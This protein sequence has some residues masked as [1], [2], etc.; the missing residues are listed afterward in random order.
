[1]Y[2]TILQRLG[3]DDLQTTVSAIR[4]SPIPVFNDV[5]Q[6]GASD[7]IASTQYCWFKCSTCKFDWRSWLQPSIIFVS[8]SFITERCP[9]CR[10]NHVPAYKIETGGCWRT[11]QQSTASRNNCTGLI[12][13]EPAGDNA[14]IS[15]WSAGVLMT[16]AGLKWLIRVFQ[17]QQA[18][19]LVL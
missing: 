6:T 8:L 18:Q 11:D 4:D 16:V 1:M 17:S 13:A 10:R 12:A 3:T 19:I 7:E 9:N 5:R 14:S 2:E 15:V